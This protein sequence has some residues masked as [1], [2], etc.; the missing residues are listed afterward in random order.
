MD[1]PI[2]ASG[3]TLLMLCAK[4]SD[5]SWCNLSRKALTEMHRGEA[6]CTS[7]FSIRICFCQGIDTCFCITMSMT[8]GIKLSTR[9]EHLLVQVKDSR[10][11][12]MPFVVVGT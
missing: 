6:N 4:T 11:T 7:N 8:R 3:M 10:Q 2:F 9:K 5:Q 1:A 12:E